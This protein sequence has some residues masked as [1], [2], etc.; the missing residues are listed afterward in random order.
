MIRRFLPFALVFVAS[1]ALAQ[2][3]QTYADLSIALYAPSVATPGVP[4]SVGF[5]Y[6]NN[7]LTVGDTGVTVTVGLPNGVQVVAMPQNCS[8][9]AGVVTCQ[10]GTVPANTLIVIPEPDFEITVV[11]V[12]ASG[13]GVLQFTG[14]IKGNEPE[15]VISNNHAVATVAVIRTLYVTDTAD[16]LADAIDQA[17][18]RCTDNFP[19]KIAF[20]LGTPP[21]SGYFTLK[22]HRAL[23]KITGKHVFIDGSTQTRLTGD[24]NPNGPEIFIDGSENAWEDAI[25]F[26]ER[27]G[28]ELA[29]VAI[30]NFKNAAVSMF[31][32]PS[33]VTDPCGPGN[34]WAA[35][36]VHDN[37]LGVDPTGTHAAPNGRGVV[38][39]EKIIGGSVDNNL[40]SGNHRSGVWIGMAF[41]PWVFSNTIGIDIRHQPLPN[42]ASGVFAGPLVTDL[43]IQDNYIAFNHDFGIAIDR[44]AVGV[45]MI[46]NSIFANLQP[47]IDIGL[48]G[49]TPDRD[50]PAPVIVSA[51]YDPAQNKT[52][53]VVSAH[54]PVVGDPPD[55]ALYASDAPHPSGYGDGQYFLGRQQFDAK[56]GGVTMSVDG[57]WRGKWA[58]ATVTRNDFIFGA[59][60]ATTSEFSRAVKVE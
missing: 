7:S 16:S 14:D 23:P 1:A 37:Y 27:C 42:G 40:I 60:H 48:D 34:F 2:S 21:A 6:A 15:P 3:P 26:D 24:T 50:I 18:L 28:G 31:G 30:G 53:V 10:I 4:F 13:G 5:A 58:A 55:L 56:S 11:A 41:Q 25:V 29:F 17:N 44:R 49:P 20:Q 36:Y 32:G 33:G 35:P 47:G 38:I 8:Q 59:G 57:D 54:E 9:S 39:S 45:N 12:N 52:I 22:P 19:C 51:Q 43:A 46:G